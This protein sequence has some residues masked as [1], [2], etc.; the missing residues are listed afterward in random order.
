MKINDVI[1]EKMDILKEMEV[2]N[3]RVREVVVK[4]STE[5]KIKAYDIGVENTMNCLKSLI[6]HESDGEKDRLIYQKY[7]AQCD[8]V[9]YWPLEEVLK[10]LGVEV[11]ED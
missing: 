1:V 3:E 5:E 2:L 10:E 8:I 9:T 6:V 7:G 4:N 11:V